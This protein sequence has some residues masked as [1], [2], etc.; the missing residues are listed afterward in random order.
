MTRGRY[1][2]HLPMDPHHRTMQRVMG[3]AWCEKKAGVPVHVTRHDRRGGWPMRM[4]RMRHWI[5]RMR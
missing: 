5:R 2:W 3:L 1:A 4:K